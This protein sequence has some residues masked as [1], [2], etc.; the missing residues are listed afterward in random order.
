MS[1]AMETTPD[2]GGSASDQYLNEPGTYHLVVTSVGENEGPKGNPIDGFTVGLSVLDGTAKG[3]KDKSTNLCLFS[4]DQSKS[5]KS[6]EW[7]RKKQ[8]A[9]AIASGLVDLKK[10]GG[11]IQIDLQT[12]VG[13]QIVATFEHDDS[14]K[15]MQLSYANIYHVDDP[16]AANFPKDKEALA[17]I[18]K[19]LRKDATYFAS[20][21]KKSES[22][23]PASRLSNSDLADL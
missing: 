7:A 12:A 4:P 16:R 14:G 22:T 21:L 20:L 9:F 8:T 11:K 17:I 13:R 1:F 23:K 18:P 19:D 6:Q 5:D 3:Q 2:I 15:Y 10:L